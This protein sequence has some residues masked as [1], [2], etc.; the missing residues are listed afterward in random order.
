METNDFIIKIYSKFISNGT[1]LF[2]F[3]TKILNK[4]YFDRATK[5]K[6]KFIVLFIL[7]SNSKGSVSKSVKSHI[8]NQSIA[9]ITNVLILNKNW[10]PNCA[11]YLYNGKKIQVD[12]KH[13]SKPLVD[14]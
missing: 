12:L 2:H 9:K 4:I 6:K 10:E 7:N 5:V 11:F 1:F 14:L 3:F 13:V 8:K